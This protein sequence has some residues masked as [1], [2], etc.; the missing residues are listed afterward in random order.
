MGQVG[1]VLAA[2]LLVLAGACSQASEEREVGQLRQDIQ[3]GYAEAGAFDIVTNTA[4]STLA[5]VTG[6]I[7]LKDDITPYASCGVTFV[8]PHYAVTAAHCLPAAETVSV[9]EIR[10]DDL[11]LADYTRI[12]GTWPDWRPGKNLTSEDGYF[13]ERMS[14]EIVVDCQSRHICDLSTPEL[15]EDPTDIAILHCRSRSDGAS[16]AHIASDDPGASEHI[17]VFWYH[18]VYD[19]PTEPEASEYWHHYGELLPNGQ[20][21]NFHY[22]YEHQLLPL[23]SYRLP[24]GEHY[25]T[26]ESDDDPRYHTA[27][28]AACSGTSGSGVFLSGAAP[29]L[30]GPVTRGASENRLCDDLKTPTIIFAKASITRKLVSFYPEIEADRVEPAD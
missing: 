23:R 8:S 30:L 29:L 1:W 24:S 14:C 18:E 2:G 16:Y 19:L 15:A 3:L 4:G 27:R 10:A 22:T 25:Y 13:A 11:N 5:S 12:D 6:A 9:E 21:E 26:Y 17:E 28:G 20:F 7:R